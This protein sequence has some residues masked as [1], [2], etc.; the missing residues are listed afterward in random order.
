VIVTQIEI[1]AIR[2][3]VKQLPVEMFQQF[4]TASSYTWMLI[5]ME[6]QYTRC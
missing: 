5:T 4:S 6:A 1:R 3:V 2:R